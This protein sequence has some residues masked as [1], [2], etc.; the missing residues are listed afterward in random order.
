MIV[1]TKPMKTN[2]NSV[3]QDFN[4]DKTQQNTQWPGKRPVFATLGHNKDDLILPSSINTQSTDAIPF[5]TNNKFPLT[6]INAFKKS[7]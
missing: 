2:N 1:T 4:N 7:S 5:V 3:K 6:L